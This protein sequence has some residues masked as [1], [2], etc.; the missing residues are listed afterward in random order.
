MKGVI[1]VSVIDMIA[2]GCFAVKVFS[3]GCMMGKRGKDQ[4]GHMLFPIKAP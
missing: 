3:L 1:A 2:V 4:C